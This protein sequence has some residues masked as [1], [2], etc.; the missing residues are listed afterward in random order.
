MDQLQTTFNDYLEF[1]QSDW[2]IVTVCCGILVVFLWSGSLSAS[3]AESRLRNPWTHFIIGIMI[4]VIY[5]LLI[6]FKLPSY[7]AKSVKSKVKKEFEQGEGPPPVEI[8]PPTLDQDAPP[9]IVD[10]EM[11]SKPSVIYDQNYFKQIAVDIS[12]NYKGPFLLTIKDEKLKAERIID[13]L[14]SVVMIEFISADGKLQNMR[15]PYK[16]IGACVE[17]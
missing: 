1:L 11:L 10:S 5:P 8:A 12:G 14:P 3:I 4:P 17:L 16:S 2:G 7:S 9:A 13:S 6:L 15:I